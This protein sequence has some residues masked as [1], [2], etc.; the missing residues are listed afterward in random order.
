MALIP[1]A[2]LPHGGQ[3][4]LGGEGIRTLEIALQQEL[5]PFA[6]QRL[7]RLFVEV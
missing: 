1:A 7:A 6:E 5:S 3:A 2:R 4:G